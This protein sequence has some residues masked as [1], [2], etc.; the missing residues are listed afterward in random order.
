MIESAR[1]LIIGHRGDSANAPE[2]TLAALALAQEKGS[3]GVEFDVRLA[4]DG[5]P[6][7]IHDRDLRRTAGI[8]GCVGELSSAEL[9]N[10]NAG[11]DFTRR[12]PEAMLSGRTSIPTLRSSLEL[13]SAYDGLAYIELKIDNS[14]SAEALVDAVCRA[15]R[16]FTRPD[17][18]IIKSFRLD[19]IA[20][21]RKALPDI[22][23]AALFGDRASHFYL[24]RMRLIR[25]ARDVGADHISVHY[26][27]ATPRL[28]D[29]AHQAGMPITVWTVDDPGWL[30]RAVSLGV[31][32][33]ITNDPGRMLR[34]L[35]PESGT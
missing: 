11:V 14:E 5:V 21:V 26:R 34:A 12:H 8:A 33:V 23:T 16:G 19:A 29:L 30:R 3:D 32:A 1:P 7:L 27:L 2:N 20:L 10:I 13:L 17:R 22:R 9:S 6:V 24:P 31:K 25:C 4:M 35:A 28:T 15:V 18:L